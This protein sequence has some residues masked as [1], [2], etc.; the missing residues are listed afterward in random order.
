LN[1]NK[2]SPRYIPIITPFLVAT[3]FLTIIP[4]VLHRPFAPKE[5]GRA[6]GYFPLVGI[7]IGGILVLINDLLESVFS[8]HL[9]GVILLAFWIVFSG[10]L[11][12]DGFLDTCD[13][14]FGGQTSEK[15][16]E[17]MRDERLGAYAFAGGFILL[18][19]K[20]F[21]LLELQPLHLL[22]V[23]A[24]G[25]WMVSFVLII[26]PYTRSEGLGRQMKDHVSWAQ[27]VLAAVF[28]FS[29]TW[30]I[31]DLNWAGILVAIVLTAVGSLIALFF[32]QKLGGLTGDIY[33]AICE[34]SEVLIM[35]V[36]SSTSF[37]SE[38]L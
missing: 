9:R 7:L 26:F 19:I 12:L 10:A 5:L 8:S 20:F 27:A 22:L 35:L 24:F 31:G 28:L 37:V 15:R 34:L 13:G 36:F 29:A 32:R 11:H 18:M 30:F 17:I 4:P 23:P 6:V 3:Q 16:L 2:F 33:G 38:L 21:A 25:R 1:E 14:L